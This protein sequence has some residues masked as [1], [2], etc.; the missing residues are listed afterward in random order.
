M[1]HR[2]A[3]AARR[4]RSSLRPF[5]LA[6]PAA[7]LLLLGACREPLGP[8]RIPDEGSRSE[9]A[10]AAATVPAQFADQTVASG[11]SSPT[12]M[13][14]APDG[15]L[16]IAEKGGRVR[17]VKNGSLLSTLFVTLPVGGGNERGLLGIAVHP[18]FATTRHVFV[19]HTTT[20]SPA[21]NRV[22]RL[23]ANGDVATSERAVILDPNNLGASP[24][25]NGGALGFGRDGKLYVATSEN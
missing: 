10:M 3:G 8:D 18:G 24:N 7:A 21:R 4:S 17:I 13:A 25:H 2:V 22:L 20:G 12:A 14:S 5:R 11:L 16:F 19:F 15:R 6:A 1:I 9:L 23:T